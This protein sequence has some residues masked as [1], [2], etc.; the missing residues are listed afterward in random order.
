MPLLTAEAIRAS[1]DEK[2]GLGRTPWPYHLSSTKTMQAELSSHTTCWNQ[3]CL[4]KTNQSE[5][6]KLMQPELI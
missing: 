3:E 4:M 1:R 2:V 6:A 5:L